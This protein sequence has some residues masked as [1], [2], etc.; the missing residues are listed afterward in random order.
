MNNTSTRLAER[1]EY[2]V[3]QAA[4]QRTELAQNM[5][6]WRAPLAVADHGVSAFRYIRRHPALSAGATL[7]IAAL[8]PKGS[9]K[10][11][12]RAWTVWQFARRLLRN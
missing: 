4:A 8:R 3:A 5:E 1:R 6:P 2:L 11:L 10:W 12:T 7:I 9:L